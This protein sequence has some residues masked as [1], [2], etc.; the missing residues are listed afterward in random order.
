[1]R[2][3]KRFELHVQTRHVEHLEQ[4]FRAG[5][6]QNRVLAA[7]SL[8]DRQTTA[9][10]RPL[11]PE[12]RATLRPGYA[13]GNFGSARGSRGTSSARAVR[14]L[15]TTSVQ[16]RPHVASRLGVKSPQTGGS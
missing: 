6:R 8:H 7:M 3:I 14:Q 10:R 2:T 5:I 4:V 9:G 16:S 1:M 11:A 15:S 12:P 13:G